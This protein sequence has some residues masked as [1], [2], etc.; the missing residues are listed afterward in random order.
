M[1]DG[2]S[3]AVLCSSLLALVLSE[4]H[5]KGSQFFVLDHPCVDTSTS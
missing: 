3:P 1:T 2:V 5:V 4:L